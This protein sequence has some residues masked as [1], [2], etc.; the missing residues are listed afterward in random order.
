MLCLAHIQTLVY[1]YCIEIYYSTKLKHIKSNFPLIIYNLLSE[2]DEKVETENEDEDETKER[3]MNQDELVKG[4][5]ESA[6]WAM[7]RLI[8]R[9]KQQYRISGGACTMVALFIF[10]KLYLANAGD[11]RAVCYIPSVSFAWCIVRL[12]NNFFLIIR[13]NIQ[14][15]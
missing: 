5:I 14:K 7:D 3:H 15:H 9:D 8:L 12:R 4:A 11:S 1:S 10:D 2:P 6:F 13:C